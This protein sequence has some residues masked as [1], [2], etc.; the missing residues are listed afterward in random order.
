MTLPQKLKMLASATTAIFNADG[1]V[2]VSLLTAELAKV[3]LQPPLDSTLVTTAQE[4]LQNLNTIREYEARPEV[5]PP[6]LLAPW[7]NIA[8]SL[9]DPEVRPLL[10]LQ[11]PL[12]ISILEEVL[13]VF[14]GSGQ[15]DLLSLPSDTCLGKEANDFCGETQCTDALAKK[16]TSDAFDTCGQTACTRNR[17]S[18]HV[19]H[20]NISDRPRANICSLG[21]GLPFL[22]VTGCDASKQRY[23]RCRGCQYSTHL[24]CL[25]KL[26]DKGKY[27]FIPGERA[28]I[29]CSEC[30]SASPQLLVTLLR[31]IDAASGRPLEWLAVLPTHRTKKAERYLQRV[32]N[33]AKGFAYSA[34]K[35]SDPTCLAFAG[36]YTVSDE[37]DSDEEDAAVTATPPR[38]LHPEALRQKQIRA[39]LLSSVRKPA[40]PA[41]SRTTSEAGDSQAPRDQELSPAKPLQAQLSALTLST[42]PVPQAPGKYIPPHL[43]P[44]PPARASNPIQPPAPVAAAPHPLSFGTAV[45]DPAATFGTAVRDVENAE[46]R[47]LMASEVSRSVRQVRSKV[48]SA[49]NTS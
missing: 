38:L 33:I 43:Q 39:A 31:A 5:V 10:D 6:S 19:L 2:D 35:V 46:F 48:T 9:H 21:C 1:Q 15:R 29:L 32:Q 7:F 12:F 4:A 23:G 13:A 36:D 17:I 41:S 30:L 40:R 44:Q 26:F 22:P 14:L 24:A 27:A 34:D 49:T 3:Q 37:E 47:E 11:S 20:N 8:Y 16:P 18:F 42:Q 45:S 25:N 28:H